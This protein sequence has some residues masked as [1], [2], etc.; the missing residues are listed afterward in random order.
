[1]NPDDFLFSQEARAEHEQMTELFRW[2]GLTDLPLHP[3]G[4]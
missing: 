2:G 1:V 4:N 3:K